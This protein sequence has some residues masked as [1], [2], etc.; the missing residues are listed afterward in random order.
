MERSEAGKGGPEG[1]PVGEAGRRGV[2]GFR[3]DLVRTVTHVGSRNIFSGGTV[4]SKLKPGG[5]SAQ[6]GNDCLKKNK[7]CMSSQ[8]K[9][10]YSETAKISKK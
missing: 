10:L 4:R 8:C 7:P 9:L 6:S 1:N 2:G 3:E 5:P